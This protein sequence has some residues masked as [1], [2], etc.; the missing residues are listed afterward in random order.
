M[1]VTV[2]LISIVRKSAMLQ[3]SV[4]M[5]TVPQKKVMHVWNGMKVRKLPNFTFWVDYSIKKTV[6]VCDNKIT[7]V[8]LVKHLQRPPVHF[9]PSIFI[10]NKISVFVTVTAS[11]K[12]ND[13]KCDII[14]PV[15]LPP[16]DKK[17][18]TFLLSPDSMGYRCQQ[19]FTTT[20]PVVSL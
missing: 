15:H 17:K 5:E 1:L 14:F 19:W 20:V 7:L 13:T 16:T 9:V 6:I 11:Q 8:R 4:G 12:L 18:K 10:L 3:K 2:P